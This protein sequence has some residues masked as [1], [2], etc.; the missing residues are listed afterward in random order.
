MAGI[1]K[2]YD[3]RGVYPTEINED[4]CYRLGRIYGAW[5]YDNSSDKEPIDL[6]VG[7]DMRV[8]SPALAENL[9]Q[10]LVE[11]GIIVYDGGLLST[12]SFYW[13]V[14][15]YKHAGGLQVSASHNPKEYNGIK[16]V[17]PKASPIGYDT[18]LA[19]LERLMEDVDFPEKRAGGEIKELPPVLQ[20]EVA[21][22]ISRYDIHSLRPLKIIADTANGMGAQYLQALL[23]HLPV[24]LVKMNFA[25]DGTFPVHQADPFQPEN[26]AD[27]RRAVVAEKAD[28]G[29][30]TDGDG[31]RIFFIDNKGE[32]IDPAIVRGI[33]AKAVLA[34]EPG[35]VIGYDIRPGRITLDMIRQYGGKPLLTKV[36]H[37]LIK[38][39]AIAADAAFAGESSGHFFYRRPF[40]FFERPMDVI[41]D[42]WQELTLSGK[43]VAKFIQPLRKYYH[44]GEINFTV[45]D[46]ATKLNELAKYFFDSQQSDLDGLSIVYPDWWAN[47]RASNTEPKLRLNVEAKT[48]AILKKQTK[49]L[50]DLISA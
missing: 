14:A 27:L 40:G 10:G 48:A 12:P 34:R 33:L 17:G 26:T 41:M 2:A 36:G 7:R 3:V 38:A 15:K 32:L 18:G 30:A 4:W 24:T 9:I 45:V 20:D 8:S 23:T 35:A 11:A 43:T 6:V 13:S 47:I 16:F 42:F 25:F 29:I 44:S 28:L 39:E 37:S 5:L 22:V 49:L 50:S 1:F 19:E 31:D 46:S 21:E